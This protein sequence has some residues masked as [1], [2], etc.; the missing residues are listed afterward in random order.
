MESILGQTTKSPSYLPENGN[1]FL[2]ENDPDV[3]NTSNKD[4]L[5]LRSKDLDQTLETNL[6]SIYFVAVNN[7]WS[8]MFLSPLY[9]LQTFQM[10]LRLSV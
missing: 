8:K 3:S 6:E 1:G 4:I 10:V 7:L 2:K 5:S 9:D